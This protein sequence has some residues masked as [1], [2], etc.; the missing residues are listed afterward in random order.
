MSTPEFDKFD[1]EG[2]S[3]ED[4]ETNDPAEEKLPKGFPEPTQE[5]LVE[6]EIIISEPVQVTKPMNQVA[7][8]ALSQVEESASATSD[9]DQVV[10]PKCDL[11]QPKAEQC[12]GC[13][14]YIAKALAQIGQS[15]I[16]ITAVKF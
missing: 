11:A 5:A 16:E 14:V 15:K 8:T 12:A 1:L 4:I 10:C 7:E 13:G 9:E 6:E 2:L 3:L